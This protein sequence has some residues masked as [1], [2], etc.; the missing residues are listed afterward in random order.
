L[1]FDP[2]TPA[3]TAPSFLQPKTD[4]VKD[5][6]LLAKLFSHIRERNQ[7]LALASVLAKRQDLL[8]G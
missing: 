5:K 6:Q 3:S 7:I 4:P 2:F 8:L 1:A